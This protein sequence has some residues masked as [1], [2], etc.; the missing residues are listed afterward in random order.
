MP[1]Q[2]VTEWLRTVFRWGKS[3]L[4]GI[5]YPSTQNPGGR[6]VV[7]FAN[8]N[9]VIL[10]AAELKAAAIEEKTEEWLVRSDHEKSW[11]KLV[12]RKVLREAV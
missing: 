11:L 12:R 7:L 1:T 8:R 4:D 10:T 2:V 3:S 6:S 9:D 5:V